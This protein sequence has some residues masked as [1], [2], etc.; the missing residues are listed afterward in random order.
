MINKREKKKL[1]KASLAITIAALL[2][3]PASLLLLNDQGTPIVLSGGTAA[4]APD[5]EPRPEIEEEPEPD[6]PQT[7]IRVSSPGGGG[8]GKP[9]PK[10][11]KSPA[12]GTAMVLGP[13]FEGDLF[14]GC[15]GCPDSEYVCN[16]SGGF[17]SNTL[18]I[19]GQYY[20]QPMRIRATLDFAKNQF[21][22]RLF[23]PQ[24]S[25]KGHKISGGFCNNP[26]D[27]DYAKLGHLE[28]TFVWHGE[29]YCISG[30][31]D[32]DPKEMH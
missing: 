24:C 6:T 10:A 13:T 16:L 2:I 23:C 31:L 12:Q 5:P 26:C 4:G 25:Q 17:G 28:L 1:L 7:S 14:L 8:G 29:P 30:T 3:L 19:E 11:K 32:Y 18:I 9:K 21:D 27:P 20:G 15:C 22:G